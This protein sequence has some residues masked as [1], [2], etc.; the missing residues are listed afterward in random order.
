MI[1]SRILELAVVAGGVEQE[2]EHPELPNFLWMIYKIF[3]DQAWARFLEQ[4][5][6]ILYAV[7]VAILLSVIAYFGSR[8]RE[9]IPSGLQNGVEA[10]VEI[11]DNFLM[12]IMGPRGKEF[13]PFLG[14]LFIYIFAMN[15]FGLIPGMHS[16]TSKLNI[17][18]SMAIVVFF[19]VQWT[20][21]RMNGFFGYI[22]HLAGSP[23]SAVEWAMVPLNLPLHIIGE[24]IKPVSLS[25]RLFGN[26]SGE[27]TLIWVFVGLGIASINFLNLPVGL[28]LQLPFIFLA[29]LTSFV[30][31]L[32][33]ALLS[34]IYFTL[35]FPHH[36]EEH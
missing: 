36:E 2:A 25:L 1:S 7:F 32:V 5:H 3:P 29:L 26:I 15:I 16:P 30:Q 14:T 17:T 13:I 10:V 4:Y 23:R 33:F 6:V 22:H 12:G 24:L 28:P 19:Y 35:M 9:L 34:T 18:L 11:L 8:K 21:I 20:G 27:D 31:A